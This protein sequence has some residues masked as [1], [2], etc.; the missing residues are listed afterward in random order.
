MARPAAVTTGGRRVGATTAT[1]NALDELVTETADAVGEL[2]VAA[3]VP[4][5]TVAAGDGIAA[6]EGNVQNVSLFVTRIAVDVL[7]AEAGGCH[8]DGSLANHGLIVVVAVLVTPNTVD[9][10]SRFI[11]ADSV[12]ARCAMNVPACCCRPQP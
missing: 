5:G 1:T 4:L 7:L 11:N 8:R 12:I 3:G 6:G 2:V 9:L 10:I